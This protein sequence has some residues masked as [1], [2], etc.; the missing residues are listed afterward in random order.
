MDETRASANLPYLDV[1]LRHAR[2]A[3]GEAEWLSLTLRA[4]PSF[5]AF[6]RQLQGA[7]GLG[8]LMALNPFVWWWQASELAMRPWLQAM[9]MLPPPSDR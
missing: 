3:E 1:E 4:T 2:D 5:A 8:P 7:A 9:G 6:E